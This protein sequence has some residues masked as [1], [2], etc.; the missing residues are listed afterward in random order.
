M[1]GVVPP[2]SAGGVVSPPSAGGVLSTGVEGVGVEVVPPS[3][4]AVGLVSGLALTTGLSLGSGLA[5]TSG[6][7]EGS[8]GHI[9]A[10]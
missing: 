1:G 8:G 5:L 9:P 3:G 4:L 2:P 6:S 10:A 7:S